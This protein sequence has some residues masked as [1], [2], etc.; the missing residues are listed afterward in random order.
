[1]SKNVRTPDSCIKEFLDT[2]FRGSKPYTKDKCR[3]SLQRSKKILEEGGFDA[4]PYKIKADAVEYILEYHRSLGRLDTYI[5][6]EI[7]YLN[8]YLKFF[9]NEVIKDMGI[10]F[11]ADMRVNVQWLEEDQYQ[12]LMNVEK[13]P[14][15]EMVIHLELRMGLRNAECCRITL[16]DINYKRN[17]AHI[18]V[19]GKGRGDG[20]YRSVSFNVE[21]R[22]VI[23]RW[24][25]E[26]A[27][28]VKIAQENIPYWRDPGY[29]LLWCHYK[30]RP[31]VGYYKEHTG[32]LD[33]AVLDPL[34]EKLGF[35]F[36]NH[37]LR[38]TFG[39]RLYLAGVDIETVAKFLGHESTVESLRYIGVNL[40]DM[41]KG[42]ELLR[43]YDAKMGVNKA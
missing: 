43:K 26:R 6:G 13:T 19:R 39:R 25:E 35:H 41:E 32:S 37:D 22:E 11:S 20:K 21:T 10:K 30:N 15:Q 34:R 23:D 12:A 14:L 40:D 27:K 24:M 1:M 31:E 16:D 3:W 36:C 17:G 33:D 5:K 2:K 18:N 7:A 4:S 8:R 28:I 29:L 38:R 42:M 9:K